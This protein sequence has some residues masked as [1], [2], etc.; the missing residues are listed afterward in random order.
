M[1]GPFYKTEGDS[2]IYSGPLSAHMKM[3]NRKYIRYVS[4]FGAF[5]FIKDMLNNIY[6][7]AQVKKLNKKDYDLCFLMIR[8]MAQQIQR[9]G[10]KL[11]V[12]DWD[13]NNWANDRIND[14]PIS[15][16]EKNL[17]NLQDLNVQVIRASSIINLNGTYSFISNDGHPSVLS[18][19]K[20]ADTLASV[21]R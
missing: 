15:M 9:T 21:I 18:N 10:G 16:I 12:I 13:K 17:N 3:S 6:T 4:L 1:G 8:K 11:I 19:E 2:L 5:T 7:N 14:L 20:L